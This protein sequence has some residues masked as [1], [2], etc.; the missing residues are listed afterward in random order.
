M[1]WFFY[2]NG[3]VVTPRPAGNFGVGT[4]LLSFIPHFSTPPEGFLFCAG[5]S[6]LRNDYLDLFGAIGTRYGAVDDP[7]FNVPDFR[8]RYPRGVTAAANIGDSTKTG[9]SASGGSGGVSTHSHTLSAH[10]HTIPGTHSHTTD[11]HTHGIAHT[12]FLAP[13]FH[14]KGGYYLEQSTNNALLSAGGQQVAVS[15]HKHISGGHSLNPLGNLA[16]EYTTSTA[17]GG[18]GYPTITSTQ[19]AAVTDIAVGG[20][21]STTSSSTSALTTG[22]S[23]STDTVSNIPP[24][25]TLTFIIKY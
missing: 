23:R 7:Y 18:V 14:G 24:Y 25:L 6:F 15:T 2:N 9:S 10:G 11:Q 21:T 22:V 12:H 8:G 16:P 13:H 4:V 17:G 20:G 1:P 5:G 3:S 19:S